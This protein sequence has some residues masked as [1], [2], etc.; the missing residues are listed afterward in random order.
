MAPATESP[1]LKSCILPLIGEPVKVT[2]LASKKP[3][4]NVIG[5]TKRNDAIYGLMATGPI[6]TICF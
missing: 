3:D 6:W 2:Y 5:N 1:Y 4:V